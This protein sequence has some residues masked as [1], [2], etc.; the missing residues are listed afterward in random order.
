MLYLKNSLLISIVS[1]KTSD[2]FVELAREAGATG[3]T[4]FPAI[5]T[6]SSSILQKLGLGDKR[7]EVVLMLL[8]EETA[9]QVIQK[10]QHDN[11]IQGV[12]ALIDPS[13]EENMEKSW[14]MITVIV[15]AGYSDDIMDGARKAGATGGTITHAR[16]TAPDGVQERFL[17]LTIVPEKEMVMILAESEKVD[18]IVKAINDMPCLKE[19]GIGIIYVQ[20]VKKF[21]NLGSSND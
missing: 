2:R 15:N 16:G 14:K 17:G 21:V 1:D 7:K 5:G 6:A 8:N 12:S 20:D 10:A 13:E 11:K 19:P 18:N 3:A 4:V 9:L